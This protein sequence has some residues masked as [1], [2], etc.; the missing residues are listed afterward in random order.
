[1]TTYHATVINQIKK[2]YFQIIAFDGTEGM[3]VSVFCLLAQ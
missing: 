1:M 2:K 3:V